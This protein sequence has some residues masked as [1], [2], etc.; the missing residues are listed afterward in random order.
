MT[1]TPTKSPSH[2][3]GRVLGLAAVAGV[4]SMSAPAL[5]SRAASRAMRERAELVRGA[6]E[7]SSTAGAGTKIEVSVP[8][9][10][11]GRGKTK[12]TIKEARGD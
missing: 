11:A 6:F 3:L 8:L 9:N 2:V 12:R 1:H 4:G 7:L 10:A 5:L